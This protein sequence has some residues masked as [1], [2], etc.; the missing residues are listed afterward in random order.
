[1]GLPW[2]RCLQGRGGQSASVGGPSRQGLIAPASPSHCTDTFLLAC[3]SM[4]P[5]L[6]STLALSPA[7]GSAVAQETHLPAGQQPPAR[8][9]GLGRAR[10]L[11]V[12]PTPAPSGGAATRKESETAGRLSRTRGRSGGPAERVE[13]LV[14]F[15][16]LPFHPSSS[17]LV[18]P[19]SRRAEGGGGGEVGKRCCGLKGPLAPFLSMLPPTPASTS[20]R[21]GTSL[22]GK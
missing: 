7:L 12:S 1:M 6:L 21:A 4:R 10:S 15:L 13:A 5:G 14:P 22:C 8:W 17:P 11:R 9:P 2:P 16:S 18:L 20:Q 3:P 19:Q